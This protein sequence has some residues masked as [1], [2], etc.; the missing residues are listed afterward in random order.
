MHQG[1]AHREGPGK[2]HKRWGR[3]DRAG[4]PW[5]CRQEVRERARLRV[6]GQKANHSIE[7]LPSCTETHTSLDPP[8]F[9][10]ADAPVTPSVRRSN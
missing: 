2:G 10:E 8:H 6:R 4:W 9:S 7:G 1:G 5:A 3:T